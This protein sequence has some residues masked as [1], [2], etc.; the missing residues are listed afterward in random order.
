MQ[1][2][3]PMPVWCRM[4]QQTLDGSARGWYDKLPSGSIDEWSDLRHLF[5][6]RFALRK[7]CFKDPTEITKIVRNANES[8]PEFKERWTT[9]TGFIQGVPEIM[10]I[11]S[12]MDACKTPELAKRFADRV[13]KTVEEMMNRLDDFVRSERAFA[14]TELPRGERLES[15]RRPPTGH[16]RREER[17]F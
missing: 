11:S 15:S 6:T 7:K 5:A 3:W 14:S 12:F 13:P 16:F 1:G 4:F 9:E 10:R 17:Q 2:C 8:L